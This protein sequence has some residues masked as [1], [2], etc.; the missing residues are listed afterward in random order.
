MKLIKK[1]KKEIDIKTAAVMI[2]ATLFLVLREYHP[3]AENHWNSILYYFILPMLVILLIFK[4]KPKEYG[5]Q[6]GDWKKGLKYVGICLILM[7]FVNIFF[8]FFSSIWGY[9]GA[10]LTAK[11]FLVRSGKD[12]ISTF[13]WEFILRGFLLFGLAKRFGNSAIVIQTVPFVL[14]HLGKPEIETLGTIVSG[15]VLGYI[16]LRSKSFWPAWITHFLVG[17]MLY[18]YIL[19]NNMM[20]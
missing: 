3:I 10:A 8:L 16:A 11:E 9:Y 12:F 13:G 6:V 5:F 18:S 20:V 15:L 14:L 4:D 19:F 7:I 17:L 1:L 2:F